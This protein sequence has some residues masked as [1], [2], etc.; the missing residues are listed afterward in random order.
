M[1]IFLTVIF[2]VTLRPSS[3]FP[4]KGTGTGERRDVRTAADIIS[5]SRQG[6]KA[7]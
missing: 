3:A 5:G 7:F 4:G 1:Q 2:K 6:N